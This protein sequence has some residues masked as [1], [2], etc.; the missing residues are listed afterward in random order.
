M[1]MRGEGTRDICPPLPPDYAHVIDNPF[2]KINPS[3]IRPLFDGLQNTSSIK[4]ALDNVGIGLFVYY[5]TIH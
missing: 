5:R 1:R 3:G 4:I 2:V